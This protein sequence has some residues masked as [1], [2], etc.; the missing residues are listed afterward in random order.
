MKATLAN[1]DRATVFN[2]AHEDGRSATAAFAS[3]LSAST[4][5]VSSQAARVVAAV[6]SYNDRIAGNVA[7]FQP[8]ARSAANR[9][10][11]ADI[12]AS[13]VQALIEAGIA[14]GRA[15][16]AAAANAAA[17]DPGNA[18]LRVQ[19]R[20]R[21]TAMD[22]AGQAAFAQRASLEELA[23]LMEAGRSYFEATPDPVWQIVED[24]YVIKR[25][26]VRSGLQAEFQRRPDLNDPLAFGADEGAAMDAARQSLNALRDRSGTVDEVR[27]AVQSI[28]DVVAVATDLSRD[29][30]YRLLTTG[31]IAE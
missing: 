26:I 1:T 17:V 21:F 12:M 16:A 23:A 3:S 6:G 4:S 22:A 18:A 15:A 27:S 31:K 25:H 10:D 24:Q 7:R 20:D 29:Q 9:K 2:V 8:D 30:A 28:I 11:A 5:P 14:E 19:V 13:P